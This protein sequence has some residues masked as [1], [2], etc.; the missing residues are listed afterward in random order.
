MSEGSFNNY[1]ERAAREKFQPTKLS[2]VLNTIPKQD[3][4]YISNIQGEIVP[5]SNPTDFALKNTDTF[6]KVRNQEGET[7]L[8]R[9]GSFHV[10][11]GV[12]VNGAGY[13]VLSAD[14]APVE[15]VEGF[16]Q[17]IGVAK[18]DF[19][20]LEKVG[21]NS[22]KIKNEDDVEFILENDEYVL[23]GSIEKSNVNSVAT[24]VSLID[25]HRQFEQMQKAIK[26]KG[27]M[28][29]SLIDK[30]GRF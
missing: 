17:L 6:F 12:L 10:L 5:T 13:E 11:D 28:S 22:Y 2:T 18:T 27:E 19:T 21:N 29:K 16:E 20:N 7:L 15:A 14:D 25:A 23:Q 9:D 8:S 3:A 30:L 24:M 1:L 4:K 26:S